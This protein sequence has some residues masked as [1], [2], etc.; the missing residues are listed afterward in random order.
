MAELMLAAAIAVVLIAALGFVR[1]VRGPE[2]ADRM[3]AAQLLGSAA[4]ASL[5]LAAYGAAAP[6]LLDLAL[7]IGLLAAFASFVYARAATTGRS[8]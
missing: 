3:M 4:A 6:A 8:S 2:R 5:L 1:I 7:V